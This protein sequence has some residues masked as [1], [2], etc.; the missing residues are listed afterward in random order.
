[1][2]ELSKQNNM[3]G[4]NNPVADILM[5]RVKEGSFILLV[6]I[7][8]F[9]LISL[10]SFSPNDPGWTLAT[11]VTEV[12]NASGRA[13]AWFSSYFLHLFGY[14]AFIFPFMVIYS[15]YLLFR[16][17]KNTLPNSFMFWFFSF[18]WIDFYTFIRRFNFLST[19]CRTGY[20]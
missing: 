13:G 4:S 9:L 3:K 14:L 18:I 20:G 6:A 17:R 1:M 5:I 2:N 12:E 8:V 7:S 11:S 19:F 15:G 16:E 10:I